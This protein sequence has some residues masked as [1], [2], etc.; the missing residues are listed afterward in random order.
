MK[1]FKVMLLFFNHQVMSKSLQ[2]HRLQYFRLLCE[3]VLGPRKE[4]NGP[5]GP[6]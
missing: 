4:N 5:K 6:C 3:G 2:P 1:S